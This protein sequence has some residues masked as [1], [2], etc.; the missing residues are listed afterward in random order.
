MVDPT[1]LPPDVQ[2]L[3]RGFV[4]GLLAILGPNL[5]GIYL[6]G[7]I[8]FA[9]DG[10]AGDFDS[11]VILRSAPTRV[12]TGEIDVLYRRV[13]ADYPPLGADIDAYFITLDAARA[14]AVPRHLLDSA[15]ADDAWPLHCAHIR[16]GRYV[17]LYG[18]EPVDTFPLPEW[19]AIDRALDHELAFVR[20][21]RE[22]PA[23][24]ILNLCRILYSYQTGDVV[25]SKRYSGRWASG[26]YPEWATVI[27]AAIRHYDGAATSTDEAVMTNELERFLT[28]ME[29][30]I[31]AARQTPADQP[32]RGDKSAESG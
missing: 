8:A 25:V 27:V 7:A 2:A 31:A 22:Y 9:E 29:V 10:P 18:P 32:H 30:H 3:A 24:C 5:Y 15:I 11:H 19:P 16:A 26:M 12:E 28:S 6:Y 23:Y 17:T 4:D 21:S 13:A 14:T 20:A 1:R